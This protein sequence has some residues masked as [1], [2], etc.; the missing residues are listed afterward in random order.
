MSADVFTF[1][2]VS[3]NNGVFSYQYT[4]VQLSMSAYRRVVC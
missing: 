2:R 1:Y 4:T 3:D